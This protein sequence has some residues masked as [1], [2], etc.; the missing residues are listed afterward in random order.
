[1]DN[2]LAS[3]AMNVVTPWAR[4]LDPRGRVRLRVRVRP[5]AKSTT[6]GP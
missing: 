2:Y 3:D 4:G 6:N 5:M 1:M